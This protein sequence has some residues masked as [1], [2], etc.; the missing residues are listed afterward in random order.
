MTS[1]LMRAFL[2]LHSE[3][4]GQALVEYA[5]ILLLVATAS[6]AI[7]GS[8]GGFVSSTFSHINADFP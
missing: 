3:E 4:E 2:A 1:R 7:L 6:I 5:L 8:F